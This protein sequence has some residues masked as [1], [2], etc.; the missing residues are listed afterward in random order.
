MAYQ[1]S[2]N[3]W[4]FD[5][6]DTIYS[7]LDAVCTAK[8]SSKYPD[9][10]VTTDSHKITNA[11]FPN[12]YLHFLSPIEVGKDLDGKD[13]NAIYLTAEISVT[14]TS[15]QK[16]EVAREVTQIVVDCMKEMRFTASLSEFVDTDTEY[17]TVSRFARTIGN[18][19]K[20]F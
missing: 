5:I 8:L 14:V 18:E 1:D 3:S 13:V 16:M 2:S 10:N 17:R 19:E 7:R 12:V 6:Q 11:K 4:V 15:A 20:L 9:L